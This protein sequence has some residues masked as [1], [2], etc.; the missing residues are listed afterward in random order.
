ML[1][2]AYVPLSKNAGM[3][4]LSAILHLE[5]VLFVFDFPP[6]WVSLPIPLWCFFDGIGG[7]TSNHLA[8]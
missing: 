3:K 7:D 2:T 8:T 5:S 4:L 1:I 6:F